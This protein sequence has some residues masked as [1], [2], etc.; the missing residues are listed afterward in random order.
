MHIPNQGNDED[1]RDPHLEATICL[2]VN[3]HVVAS[4]VT[5]FP[6]LSPT[7]MLR[8]AG[9]KTLRREVS[10]RLTRRVKERRT[11]NGVTNYQLMDKI[12]FNHYNSTDRPFANDKQKMKSVREPRCVDAV[13]AKQVERNVPIWVCAPLLHQISYHGLLQLEMRLHAPGRT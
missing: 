8:P 11:P 2:V 12:L 10:I 13:R 9:L 6:G 3:G 1:E 5:V 7:V 4:V